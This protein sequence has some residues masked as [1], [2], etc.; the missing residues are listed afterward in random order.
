MEPTLRTPPLDVNSSQLLWRFFE[1]ISNLKH[2]T[3]LM[4]IYGTGLRISESLNLRVR[5]VDS[6]RGER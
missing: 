1:Q 2:R 6:D 4:T 5:D 3:V